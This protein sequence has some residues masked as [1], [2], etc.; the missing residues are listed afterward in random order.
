VVYEFR[1]FFSGSEFP[2]RERHAFAG[3]GE[4]RARAAGDLLRMPSRRAVTVWCGD[5]L[6]WSRA[7]GAEAPPA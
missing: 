4:A 2:A 3:D 1:F 7:R 6:V 5:R